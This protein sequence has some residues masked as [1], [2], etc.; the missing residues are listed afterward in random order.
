MKKICSILIS[1]IFLFFYSN[2]SYAIE[3]KATVTVILLDISGSM[4]ERNSN[5]KTRIN[6]ALNVILSM[7][8]NYNDFDWLG[9]RTI[10]IPPHKVVSNIKNEGPIYTTFAFSKAYRKVCNNSELVVEIKEGGASS[11]RQMIPTITANGNSTPIEYTLKQTIEQD[12]KNFPNYMKKH[13]ILITDGYEGCGGN[14]C[15]YIK[16]VR[17]ERDDI[18]IDVISM[19]DL[20]Q[21]F[22]LYSC[23]AETTG[24]KVYSIEQNVIDI[25]P[26]NSDAKANSTNY[27]T[28]PFI[29]KKDPGVEYRQFL[30]EFN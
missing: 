10:G 5:N 17:S 30:L 21:N 22:S 6:N 23:L 8:N 20:G 9:L 16:K 19:L 13:I 2:V 15:S 27:S 11:I 26:L 24:G 1:I 25:K 29:S 28:L 12:F 3:T 4:R 14:P 7:L 18:V